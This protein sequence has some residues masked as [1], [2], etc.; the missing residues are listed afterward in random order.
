MLLSLLVS[1]NLLWFLFPFDC[2]ISFTIA[3][4]CWSKDPS[5]RPTI[6][7]VLAKLMTLKE[8]LCGRQHR[9][10]VDWQ[11]QAPDIQ[12]TSGCELTDSLSWG[13]D[14]LRS[15]AVPG[16]YIEDVHGD[17]HLYGNVI[18]ARPA[19]C[20]SSLSHVHGNVYEDLPPLPQIRPDRWST[21]PMETLQDSRYLQQDMLRSK[22]PSDD[23]SHTYTDMNSSK[24][25]VSWR[26]NS[27][28]AQHLTDLHRQPSGRKLPSRQQARLGLKAPVMAGQLPPGDSTFREVSEVPSQSYGN[29]RHGIV[30]GAAQGDACSEISKAEHH[31][32][33]NRVVYV[34]N[35]IKAG[36]CPEKCVPAL[37][38][39]MKMTRLDELQEYSESDGNQSIYMDMDGTSFASSLQT[40]L[41]QQDATSMRTSC[42]EKRG[43]DSEEV[44]CHTLTGQFAAMSGQPMTSTPDKEFFEMSVM[45][46]D[47]LGD[48]I[49]SKQSRALFRFTNGAELAVLPEEVWPSERTPCDPC[50][51]KNQPENDY[52]P[53]AKPVSA[54]V[55]I[56]VC[57]FAG[58]HSGE[59]H[60]Y[61]N[62]Q[63]TLKQQTPRRNCFAILPER[64]TSTDIYENLASAKWRYQN[65][66]MGSEDDIECLP[67]AEHRKRHEDQTEDDIFE[68]G[69]KSPRASGNVIARG[70]F[71]PSTPDCGPPQLLWR[72][73]RDTSL[74][75]TCS[76]TSYGSA[77]QLLST[78][79]GDTNAGGQTN[80]STLVTELET[81]MESTQTQETSFDH[82][83][84]S[85]NIP[86]EEDISH[87]PRTKMTI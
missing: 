64:T 39:C 55:D 85:V 81:E 60:V 51:I 34:E 12:P 82:N 11:G 35:E 36:V 23:E 33:G 27:L 76:N 38:S 15:V 5:E 32:G 25:V 47:K 71:L 29:I 7:S 9:C 30:V 42:E 73:R 68:F 65:L 58:S 67:R 41:T 52:E 87:W 72:R 19:Q 37:A 61:E 56:P 14:E 62:L 46:K 45:G 84:E 6:T 16:G 63:R 49:A 13:L 40:A 74:S 66:R 26:S 21:F 79:S 83:K 22:K 50:T 77:R 44:V 80:F 20:A 4:D 3:L 78:S 1:L 8:P 31:G 53:M 54:A 70:G 17:G 2:C 59:Q 75:S 57:R 48:Q 18:H 24:S 10:A 69:P 28:Q 86:G 43:P